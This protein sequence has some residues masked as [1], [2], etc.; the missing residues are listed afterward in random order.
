MTEELRKKNLRVYIQQPALP[1]YRVP[2]FEE[3]AKRER[4]SI[5]LGY[6]QAIGLPN[7]AAEEL[8]SEFH[9]QRFVRFAGQELSWQPIPNRR[10]S[11]K[12]DVLVLS[13]AARNV[14]LLPS[15]L[16]A[17][18]RRIGVVLW[19]HGYTKKPSRFRD[20]IRTRLAAFADAILF[21]DQLTM[22]AFV[23]KHPTFQKRTFVAPN[24]LL[25]SE[26][27]KARTY[28]TENSSE[29]DEFRKAKS[30]QPASTV[31]MVSRMSRQNRVDILIR[32]AQLLVQ[33]RPNL[34]I[35]LV[36]DATAV[37]TELSELARNL[38][39]ADRIEFVGPCYN[40]RDLAKYFLTADVYCYPQNVG[41]SILHAFAYGVPVITSDRMESH[42]PEIVA[43]RPGR[44]GDLFHN[45]SAESLAEKVSELLDDSQLRQEMSAC[46]VE[47]AKS[48]SVERMVDGI[49]SA[50]QFAHHS[51]TK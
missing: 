28:W 47:T 12:F 27:E 38:G 11:E 18:R 19:G 16:R 43:L 5:V 37:E 44:N 13:W 34:R 9:Q 24:A 30:Y 14:N 31:L 8:D 48:F 42:N 15:I 49:E 20:F 35:V 25:A 40:E 10:W 3:L 46:A 4:L 21:Y 39:I 41:L 50:I 29:L 2:I 36:G 7:E 22:D 17:K 26:I 33:K 51:A 6:G 23:T 32:A 45:E 1:K